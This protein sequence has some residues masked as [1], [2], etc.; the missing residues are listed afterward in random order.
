MNRMK[1]DMLGTCIFNPLFLPVY[2]P[3]CSL[4]AAGPVTLS[5]AV[6]QTYCALSELLTTGHLDLKAEKQT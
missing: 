4:F 2:A 3:I 6:S 5:T 1:R